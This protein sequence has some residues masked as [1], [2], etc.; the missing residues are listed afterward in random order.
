[1]LFA[2]V[3]AISRRSASSA[4]ARRASAWQSSNEP[5][6]QALANVRRPRKP[7]PFERWCGIVGRSRRDQCAEHGGPAPP[8]RRRFLQ[9]E[10]RRQQALFDRGEIAAERKRRK[11]AAR[12]RFAQACG[13]TGR[14]VR[15]PRVRHAKILRELAGADRLRGKLVQEARVADREHR[16]DAGLVALA[17]KVRH[18]VL[19][20]VDVAQMA[21][22]R[23]MSVVPADVRFD[24]AIVR[25]RRP[26]Q[27]YGSPARDRVRHRDEVVLAADA[28]DDAAVFERVGHGRAEQRRHHARIEEA[29]IAPLR[30][31]ERLASTVKLVDV[32]HAAHDEPVVV[33][34]RKLA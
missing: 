8:V 25:A 10:Q 32:R 28:A 15:A 3:S 5:C 34:A 13:E 27:Q 23:R 6:E 12:L 17:A 33:G 14:R 4:S 2:E 29:R 30:Y 7:E 26:Q 19:G 18:A 9:P 21:R 1:M 16:S 24:A 20:H 22:N 31:I 11:K